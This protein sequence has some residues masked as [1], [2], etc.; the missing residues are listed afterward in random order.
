LQYEAVFR[1]VQDAVFLVDMTRGKGFEVKR[2][3]RAYE[4]MT[5][6][7]TDDLRGKTPSDILGEKDAKEVEK[8]Y[9]EC[10]E[11]RN[12]ME[13]EEVLSISGEEREWSTRIAPVVEGDEVVQVVGATRD[14]TGG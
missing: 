14:T 9:S 8:R 2:V 3:N 5:G 7:S 10:V 1:S 11:S 12:T 4:E 6:I 13:Y